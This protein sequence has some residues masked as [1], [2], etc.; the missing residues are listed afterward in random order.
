[1][2]TAV[3]GFTLQGF[4]SVEKA[5]EEGFQKGLEL[6]GSLAVVHKGQVVVNLHGGFSDV[7]KTKVWTEKTVA[8]IFSSTKGLVAASLL[9]LHARG[10]LDY[11]ARISEHWPE[12]KGHGKENITVG[13]LLS[14][15]AGLSGLREKTSVE[16][17]YDWKLMVQKIE[18]AAPLWTPGT[19]AG[20]HAL[21]WG[22][23]VGEIVFRITGKKI[24]TYLRD[25]FAAVDVDFWVGL[26]STE[27]H[28]VAEMKPVEVV[29]EGAQSLAE[30]SEILQLTI[31]NPH[32]TADLPGNR[33]WRAA[34]VP[35]ANGQG[36]AM[37]LA[38]IYG[39]LANRGVFEGNKL[40]DPAS[41]EAATQIRFEGMDLT[42]GFETRWSAGFF[43]NNSGR[44]Y[45]PS[46]NAFG[47]SGWGGSMGFADPDNQIAI[48]YVPNQMSQDLNGDKRAMKMV[49]EVYKAI[50]GKK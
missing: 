28:R 1:M 10:L 38:K 2:K 13:T 45:G 43:M 36:N 11:E 46:L 40:F 31:L 18:N 12:F 8:N 37:A 49:S 21:T 23:I 16:D 33:N 17:L 32:I 35:G 27:E 44:Q 6:G 26:P 25:A 15:Q 14:H 48:G 20:Y 24:G 42:L 50:E 47:H 22:Y 5:F 7:K 39:A 3:R 30:L 4:E 19:Q 29:G 34:E 9:P 41:I